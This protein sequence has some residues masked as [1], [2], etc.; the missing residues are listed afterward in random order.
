MSRAEQL[1]ELVR[2][3]I[4]TGSIKPDSWIKQDVLAAELGASK[5]PLREAL[6]KLE[7]EGLVTSEPNRGFFVRPLS[8]ADAEDIFAIRLKLEPELVAEA[9]LVASDAQR[10]LAAGALADLQAEIARHGELIPAHNRAFHMALARP[11]G[12]PLATTFV[13]RLHVL[14]ERYV[15]KHLEPG[16]RGARANAEHLDLLAAWLSRDRDRTFALTR[17]HITETL[18]DLREQLATEQAGAVVQA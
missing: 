2:T 11:A 12:R 4:L 15:R 18:M 6:R 8:A 9:A 5:I 7:E 13:E 1:V 14:A 10:E 16:E 3:G 17:D